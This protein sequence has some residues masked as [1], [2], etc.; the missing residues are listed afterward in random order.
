MT[1][2]TAIEIATNYPDNILINAAQDKETSK[3]SSFMYLTRNGEIHKLMLS[4]DNSPFNSE[5]EAIA[6]MTDV[7]NS[8]IKY[9]NETYG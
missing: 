5:Q 3:W 6:T 2:L 8:A 9:Y 7:A 1:V 4:Y